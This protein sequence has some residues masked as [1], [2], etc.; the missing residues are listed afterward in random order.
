VASY[1]AALAA[2]AAQTLEA[3][4]AAAEEAALRAACLAAAAHGD[5]GVRCAWG[6]AAEAG[7][8]YG[9]LAAFPEARLAEAGLCVPPPDALR[10]AP[11]GVPP[12]GASPDALIAWPA[13]SPH[14]PP[15]AAGADAAAERWEVVEVKNSCPFRRTGSAAAARDFVLSDRGPPNDFPTQH[16]AQ[17]QL[18]MLCARTAS[19][20]LVCDSATRGAAVYRML[21]DEQ[22]LQWTLTLLARFANLHVVPGG[23]SGAAWPGGR[24]ELFS[25]GA[26]AQL[27]ADWLARTRRLAGRA[28][29]LDYIAAPRRPDEADERPFLPN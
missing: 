25:R 21:R 2:A 7:T 4:P 16:V 26:D 19:G 22:Y 24:A 12:L 13:A 10:H 11:P 6:S 29:L 20:L 23:A 3:Q 14:A 27:L 8:L 9:L 18:E 15:P 17:L 1:N 28:Q 5:S